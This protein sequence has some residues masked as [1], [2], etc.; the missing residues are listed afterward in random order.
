MESYHILAWIM[1][2]YTG[3]RL[4]SSSKYFV[5]NLSNL[6]CVQSIEIVLGYIR[7]RQLTHQLLTV[8]KCVH[9][10]QHPLACQGIIGTN[11]IVFC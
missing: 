4:D 1:L 2:L 3:K 7:L 5:S 8:Q 10:T 6:L 9:K 11:H